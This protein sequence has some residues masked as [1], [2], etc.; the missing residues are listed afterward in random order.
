MTKLYKA[1][2]RT[3]PLSGD[4]CWLVNDKGVAISLWWAS[5]EEEIENNKYG[6]KTFSYDNISRFAN[7]VIDPVLIAEW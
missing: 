2:D 1:V 3:D 5:D 7:D 6:E 4:K